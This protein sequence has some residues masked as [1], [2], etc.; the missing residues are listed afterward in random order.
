MNILLEVAIDAALVCTVACALR[1]SVVGLGHMPR[2]P[3]AKFVT[4]DNWSWAAWIMLLPWHIGDFVRGNE[5]P[6][7]WATFTEQLHKY[8]IL[9]ALAEAGMILTVDL[10]VLWIPAHGYCRDHPD[11][12]KRVALMVRALN[13]TVGLLIIN[14]GKILAPGKP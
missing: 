7:P 6:L 2:N 1:V 9:D 5:S 3:I 4:H 10:W 14:A 11:L 13:L 8:G 12:D